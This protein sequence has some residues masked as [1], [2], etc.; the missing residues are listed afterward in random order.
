[1]PIGSLIYAPFKELHFSPKKCTHRERLVLYSLS[2]GEA[3]F[4][5]NHPDSSEPLLP[6]QWGGAF[7]IL[8]MKPVEC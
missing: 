8:M 7:W 1:M 4:M 2:F 3:C 6:S 5:L